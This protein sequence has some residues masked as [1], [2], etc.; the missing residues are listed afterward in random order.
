[1]YICKTCNKNIVFNLYIDKFFS[2]GQNACDE[3]SEYEIDRMKSSVCLSIYLSLYL[4]VC[5]SI[6]QDTM[7]LSLI[8]IHN[9]HE[10]INDTGKNNKSGLIL[11]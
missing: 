7:Y 1:M 10:G 5:L 3:D 8:Y 11:I 6:N 9:I 4:S 2:S